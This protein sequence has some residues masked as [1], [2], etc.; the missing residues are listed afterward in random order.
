MIEQERLDLAKKRALRYGAL[1]IT[2]QKDASF[3]NPT[4]VISELYRTG[5]YKTSNSVSDNLQRT[6]SL[7]SIHDMCRVIWH[8]F[9]D[10][11]IEECVEAIYNAS[12]MGQTYGSRAV[13]LAN[14]S[15]VVS[16]WC[17]TVNKIVHTTGAFSE[18][19]KRNRIGNILSHLTSYPSSLHGIKYGELIR[20]CKIPK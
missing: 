17:G 10:A 4:A 3:E 1:Y 18:D 2:G 19:A 5:A 20:H 15:V 9:P 12:Y 13:E 11:T 7:R 8:Y 6:G 16:G 14:F